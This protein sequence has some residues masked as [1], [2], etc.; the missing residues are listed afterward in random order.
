MNS[1]NNLGRPPHQDILTPAEWRVVS[2]A[3]HGLTNPQIAD[4]LQ[5]SIN[6]VKY[7][8]SNVISKLQNIP[9]SKVIDKKSLLNYLG[10]PKDSPFHRNN[11]MNK[12]TPIQ[13]IGQISRTVENIEQSE[14]WYREKLGLKHLYTFGKLA[15]FDLD[16]VR[17][18]L[19]EPEETKESAAFSES[20]IY[21]KTNDIKHSHQE[22]LERGI[23]FS[24]APHKVHTHDDGTEEWMAFFTDLEGRPL[25]LMGQLK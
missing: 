21:F 17:L 2:L 18:F 1:K 9:D 13:A 25:G 19:S 7:H 14:L 6:A 12:D 20:I 11:I 5:V 23:E 16:G 24:H 15:F 8:I 22:L 10:A 4:K 3:Q